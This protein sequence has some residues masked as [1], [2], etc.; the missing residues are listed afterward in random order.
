VRR[1][2]S[3][4][5]VAQGFD[6][7]DV[8]ALA[9]ALT[10]IDDG[11]PSGRELLGR[12][13]ARTGRA[14]IVGITGSPGS[15]KSTL[16]DAMA[17]RLAQAGRRVAVIAVDPSSAFSGGAIL[18]DRIRMH[19]STQ[20]PGVFVRSMATRGHV[21]GLSRA[22]EDACDL[23]DAFGFDEVIIETVGVGQDEIEVV[24]VAHLCLVVLVP[25]M[26]DDIQAIKAGIMEIASAYVVN[27]ADRDGADRLEA[28]L[29]GMLS[30]YD[31]GARD[32]PILRTVA[33][34]GDGVDELLATLA[35]LWA[36][37]KD[38][39]NARDTRAR[40]RVEGLLR[41]RLFEAW[42][43]APEATARLE[44]ALESVRR[45]EVD[46]HGAVDALLAAD[47]PALD[48]LA[49][50]VRSTDEALAFWR[51]ALGLGV[52]H[53]ESVPS[54]GVRTTFLPLGATHVE[55]LEPEGDGPV[56]QF[57]GK[58]GPGLHHCCV[59]VTDIHAAIERLRGLG[60]KLVGEAP[61]RGAQ[62][63]LVAFVHPSS[64]G[65]VLVELSQEASEGAP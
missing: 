1:Q 6:R 29:R 37:R 54:E 49:V 11:D 25:F 12:V 19:A 7:G 38:Q 4:E 59:R 44:S 56:Q 9:R 3:V 46:P 43:A 35:R 15:G 30:L 5:E 24:Q 26:G 51:D 36:E 8:R 22:T 55:L 62:G 52:S 50:A 48:H 31:D 63:R 16:V 13:F 64:A 53:V 39:P 2:P 41:E 57:L 47:M 40:R 61:R 14:R 27:K 42:I 33:T 34:R 20:L 17:L 45:R 23:L 58:R 21:G 65:G 28:Q 32:I 60:V 10:W 18:G